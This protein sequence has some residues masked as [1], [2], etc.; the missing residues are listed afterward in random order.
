MW[1]DAKDKADLA[2]RVNADGPGVLADVCALN[3][4]KLSNSA[5]TMCLMVTKV[6]H[7]LKRT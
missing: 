4:I 1:M 7:A 5:P 6:R 2:F 3:K